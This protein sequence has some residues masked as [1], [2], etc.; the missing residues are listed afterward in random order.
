[1]TQSKSLQITEP[2]LD[3]MVKCARRDQPHETCA[4]LLGNS[5]QIDEYHGMTNVN[6]GLEELM[7]V[8]GIDRPLFET[9]RDRFSLHGNQPGTVNLNGASVDELKQIE[10]LSGELAERIVERRRRVGKFENPTVHFK[11]DPSDQLRVQRDALERGKDVVGV[12]HSHPHHD[13][14]AYPSQEDQ[15]MGHA[16]Y[17]YF[18]LNFQP[19]ET[20]IRAFE[21]DENGVTE[22][23]YQVTGDD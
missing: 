15:R 22:C 10:E 23:S 8:D 21:M 13:S 9:I 18:I 20:V 6:R 1:M 7:E 2:V 14:E 4:L 16:G 12:Y 19:D 5:N 17:V 11:F 3:Q